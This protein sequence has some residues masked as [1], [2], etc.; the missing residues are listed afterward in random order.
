VYDVFAIGDILADFTPLS[1]SENGNPVYECNPGGTAANLAVSTARFGLKTVLSGR[2][3]N[4]DIGRHIEKAVALKGV[5]TSGVV[6]DEDR[7]STQTFITLQDGERSFVFSRRYAADI[8][9]QTGDIDF[10]KLFSSKIL[11]VSGMCFSGEPCKSATCY[12][13]ERIK[14][15]GIIRTLDVNYR[16]TLWEGENYFVDTMRELITEIDVFKASEEEISL[17]TGETILEKA[18]EKINSWGPGLVLVTGGPKGACFYYR[19]KSAR[20]NTYATAVVDTTGA[21]DCFMGAVLY[22]IIRRGGIKDFSYD[23]LLDII[24]FANAAGAVSVSKRGGVTSMPSIDDVITCMK[25]VKKLD[26]LWQ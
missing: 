22:R 14:G 6:F 8:N 4:E 13:M 24:D 1:T 23:E 18:A 10:D 5:D 21:G 15:K 7:F 20:L 17:I 2:V 16:P 11:Y 19:G 25:T 3:G 26:I 9:C 12:A